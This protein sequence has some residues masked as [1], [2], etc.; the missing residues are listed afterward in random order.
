[1][2]QN[3]SL[4]REIR[5]QQAF[6]TTCQPFRAGTNS[7]W[8]RAGRATCCVLKP[9]DVP[10]LQQKYDSTFRH[11]DHSGSI[12]GQRTQ[13]PES[14]SYQPCGDFSLMCCSNLLMKLTLSETTN[15]QLSRTK[16][17]KRK[18]VVNSA[19]SSSSWVSIRWGFHPSEWQVITHD[20]FGG[21]WRSVHM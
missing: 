21:I 2:T 12:F 4:L 7:F 1:M 13:S 16:Q 14:A 8:F 3:K 20:L 18:M 17:K 10:S 9:L 5:D 19:F 6:S 15:E 11:F